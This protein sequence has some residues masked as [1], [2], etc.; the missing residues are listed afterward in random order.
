VKH[1][2]YVKEISD[3]EQDND[4]GTPR[5]KRKRTLISTTPRK[6]RS[7]STTSTPTGRRILKPIELTPLPL[8]TLSSSLLDTPHKIAQANLHVSAVP[9]SLPCREDEYAQILEYL[10][11]AIEEGTGTCIYI[12][13]V[14]GTGKT[15]TAREVV[16]ALNERVAAEVPHK[17]RRELTVGTR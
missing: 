4:Y 17:T 2:E 8:R 10:E 3:D 6:P 13:G 9:K 15:A 1:E 14:P 16:R 7:T 5:K 11:N 12:S